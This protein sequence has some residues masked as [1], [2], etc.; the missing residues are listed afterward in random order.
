MSLSSQKSFLTIKHR[1]QNCTNIFAHLLSGLIDHGE[2]AVDVFDVLVQF[3][4]ATAHVE[5]HLS[6]AKAAC[7]NA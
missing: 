5:T 1:A 4:G 6:D 3:L 7:E 2:Q